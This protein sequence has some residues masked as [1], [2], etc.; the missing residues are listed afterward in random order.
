MSCKFREGDEGAG[1][2][3]A[4]G[5]ENFQLCTQR[6]LTVRILEICESRYDEAVVLQ[7]KLSSLRSSS[8]ITK[9]EIV[10]KDLNSKDLQEIHGKEYSINTQIKIYS[11]LRIVKYSFILK[12]SLVPA[13]GPSCSLSIQPNVSSSTYSQVR[14]NYCIL[15]LFRNINPV[16]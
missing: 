3:K 6:I 16:V 7:R 1:P 5:S 9:L 11:T 10:S 12:V 13:G 4:Q 8:F 15:R 2:R 14:F